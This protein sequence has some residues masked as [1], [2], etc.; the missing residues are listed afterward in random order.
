MAEAGTAAGADSIGILAEMVKIA[1]WE[2]ERELGWWR[3]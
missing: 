1:A 3:G 2:F